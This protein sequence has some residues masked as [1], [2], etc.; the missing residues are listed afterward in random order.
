[1][2]ARQAGCMWRPRIAV[3]GAGLIG[4]RHVE[5]VAAD[6]G[7]E[8]AAIVD[9]AAEVG[10]LAR[11]HRVSRFR[12]LD[13]LFAADRPDGVVIAT[14]NQL[15]VPQAVTCI[16]AGAAV[17]VEKPIAETVE[18][19]RGLVKTSETAAPGRVPLLVGHHR[20]H[21]PFLAKAR[22]IVAGGE[23]GR[24]VAVT[25]TAVFHKPDHYFDASPWRR[26][27]GG[28]PI[29]VNLIHGI[30][31]LRFICGDIDR[32][33]ATASNRIRGFEVEDTA[34][35]LLEF[36]SGALGTFMLSDTAVSPQ[37]WEQTS[38]EDPNF[39][40]YSDED[41]YMIAGTKGSLSIPTMRLRRQTAYRSWWTAT[42]DSVP[43]VARTDPLFAQLQHF[44]EVIRGSAN[45]LVSGRDA[46]ETLRVTRLIAESAR[47][48]SI[49]A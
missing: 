7:S 26:S 24:I 33:Q 40:H 10:M 13:E 44:C 35:V 21:S 18:E 3:V 1:M 27:A 20:R 43:P 2:R 31:D 48:S 22:E 15:H 12:L 25:G 4:R 30:D 29:L 16:E 42:E 37:S 9:P 38:G 19:A 34:A 32:V 36:A 46:M 11:S 6:K 45:P 41:C 14:P 23:L 49:P 39:P 17:L 8:L 5:L 28:G 47:R